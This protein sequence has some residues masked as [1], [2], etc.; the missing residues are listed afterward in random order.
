MLISLFPCWLY[1]LCGSVNLVSFYLVFIF[2]LLLL[3]F[4]VDSELY[5]KYLFLTQTLLSF[6]N[7]FLF[8]L[9]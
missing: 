3:A 5:S 8:F 7:I 9:Q 2:D 6:N 4:L 1:Y